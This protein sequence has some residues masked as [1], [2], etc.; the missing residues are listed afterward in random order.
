MP[1]QERPHFRI[2]PVLL[3]LT[4]CLIGTVSAWWISARIDRN[5]DLSRFQT[6]VSRAAL[7]IHSSMDQ[8]L[9]LLRGARGLFAARQNVTADEWHTFVHHLSDEHAPGLQGLAYIEPEGDG[10]ADEPLTSARIRLI[11]PR[12]F[13][14]EVGRDLAPLSGLNAAMRRARDEGSVQISQV[15]GGIF[16][17]PEIREIVLVSPVYAATPLDTQA[18]RRAALRGWVAAV[19]RTDTLLADA[20]EPVEKDLLVEV[21]D[22]VRLDPVRD[23]YANGRPELAG[24]E[25]KAVAAVHVPGRTWTL[26]MRTM[27]SFFVDGD[28]TMPAFMAAGGFLATAIV[29]GVVVWISRGRA[30]AVVLSAALTDKE[31]EAQRAR[32][33]AETANASK[34]Q[35]L[36]MVS[37]E[38]RTPMA[39]ILG[40]AELLLDQSLS[41]PEH[42]ESART[43]R[44]NGEH[45]LRIINDILDLSK[46][47]AGSMDTERVPCSPVRLVEDV[48]SLLQV[49]ARPKGLVLSTAYDF[50]LPRAVRTDPVRLRQVLLNIVGNAVKFTSAGR[51]EVR[52]RRDGE[53]LV[54][55]VHDT[56]IGI[57]PEQLQ[58]LFKPFSQADSST[59]RRFGGTGLGLAISDKLTA[60]LGGRLNV[61]ST[62]NHG[63]IFTLAMPCIDAGE[64]EAVGIEDALSDPEPPEPTYDLAD[65]TLSGRILLAEDG[66]DNQRLLTFWLTRAG[67][68]VELAHNGREA[69]ERV[70]RSLNQAR[71]APH[72]D[73][74][75]MDVQ[76][77]ELD[78]HSATIRI[79]EHGFHGPVIALTAQSG[80]SERQRLLCAG[81]DDFLGKPITRERLLRTCK[82]WI[83]RS[84]P[85]A[86]LA[87]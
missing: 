86:G 73:L 49:R 66:V 64:G 8:P 5:S 26:R 45:L 23:L 3:V 70:A 69:V 56:G 31:S 44:R 54:F 72:F 51:V 80:E 13:V 14:G 74:V 50:P 79:R 62:P 37:H 28:E 29:V 33:A 16:L 71:D 46:I 84:G 38:L 11:E 59:T 48:V 55:E 32:I 9:A 36:T 83:W 41:A 61:S 47:E 81:C 85:E 77:P 34:G 4:V 7:R 78:G 58:R 68:Q 75:L 1:A 67:A 19:L 12:S 65:L 53:N 15:A 57:T 43:I 82:A 76:M 87:A 42:A 40:H 20:L 18:Q 10:P 2:G 35:F 60:L 21:F 27:P 22:G 52:T 63:S 24:S 25:F 6:V 39:A 17:P 30:A